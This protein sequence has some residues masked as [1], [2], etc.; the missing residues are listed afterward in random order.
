VSEYYERGRAVLTDAT[1]LVFFLIGFLAAGA[2]GW[3]A[4]RTAFE[5]GAY[6]R[7]VAVFIGSILGGGLLAGLLGYGV[8]ALSGRLW[9]ALHHRRRLRRRETAR[10]EAS[11]P[12]TARAVERPAEVRKHAP[13]PMTCRVGPLTPA[14]LAAFSRRLG[15]GALDRRYA[16]T[17]T[18]EILTLAAW[19]GLEIAGVAR[20]L[21]DGFGTL[22][23]TDFVVDP[24]YDRTDV[25]QRLI[26]CALERVPKGGRLTRA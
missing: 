25:E 14:N 22:V 8:G 7:G 9:Q 21:S 1:S 17:T 13:A 11:A 15:E 5:L 24:Y 16:E 2:F 20:L 3:P 4:L 10:A 26:N 19:D 18:T 6:D 12:D 23:I